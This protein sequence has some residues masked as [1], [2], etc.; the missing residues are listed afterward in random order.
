MRRDETIFKLINQELKR[1]EEGIELI[2]SENFVSKQ[3]ME[4]A[5]SVLT[6]KYAE[7]LPGKR[8]YGGCEVVDEVETIAIERAKQLFNAE[9]ANVQPHSGAQANAAVFLALLQPGDKILGFD[10]SHGGHLTHGATVNF[11]GKLYSPL[12]YGVDKETGLIDYKQLEEITLQEKPKVIICG[13]SAYSRDWDYAFIRQ[14]ADEIGALVVADVSHPAGLIARGLLTD[15]LPHCH[16]V[17]TTTHKTLR[18]PRGGLILVGKDFENPW[19]IKTPKGEI[20]SITSLLDLAVFPGTQGGPLEHI[21]A[22][23]AIAFGEALSEEYMEYIIQV[24]KNAA[25]LAKVFVDKDY[26]IISGGTDNHLM[27]IDLRNKGISGKAAEAA[28]GKAGITINKNMVPF[29]DKSPFVTSGIRL[30]TAAI[31]TRGLKEEQMLEIAEMI[32]VALLKHDDDTALGKIHNKVKMLMAEFP[33][34]K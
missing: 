15:P 31:T 22:A 29:D 17:T 32:D 1:Q 14:V 20:R 5:G 4:A 33:L 18:G 26:K 2:A 6:N 21:I 3:V 28:L 34:Y 13:A 8:Y 27:L 16:V 7:G 23:K 9:W 19:G 24:K 12:F 30:G 25:A 10:L 11:S